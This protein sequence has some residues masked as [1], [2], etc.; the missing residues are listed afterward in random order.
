VSYRV[1]LNE[2]DMQRV[3]DGLAAYGSVL[4]GG[5]HEKYLLLSLRGRLQRLQE[6]KHRGEG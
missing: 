1:T 6:D 2:E 3:I 5:H 4:P